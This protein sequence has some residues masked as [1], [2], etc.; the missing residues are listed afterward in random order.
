TGATAAAPIWS[1]YMRDIHKGLPY[2]AFPKP[3]GG[4]ASATVCATSGLLP[5]PYCD[6][7]TVNLVYL[8][9]TQPVKSCDIHKDKSLEAQELLNKL[10]GSGSPVSL[11]D[12]GNQEGGLDSTITVDLPDF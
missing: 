10:T 6:E 5:T 7:G 4:I 11:P 3:Q 9:G 2:K 1:S 8:D 12:I